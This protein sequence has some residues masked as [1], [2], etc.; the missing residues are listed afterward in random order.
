MERVLA[1][2]HP[3]RFCCAA[4]NPNSNYTPG[5]TLF[6]LVNILDYNQMESRDGTM[7]DRAAVEN[8]VAR[9]DARLDIMQDPKSPELLKQ[10]LEKCHR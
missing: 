1:P 5:R 2:F 7:L 9:L 3:G 10:W 4:S 6:L 8:S